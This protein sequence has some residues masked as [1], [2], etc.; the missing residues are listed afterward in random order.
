MH[1]NRLSF[2]TRLFV[3]FGTMLAFTLLALAAYVKSCHDASR[4]MDEILHRYS[5]KLDVGAQI[6]LATTEMQGSQRGLMLSYAMNDPHAAEQYIQLYATSGTKI[7]SV[8]AEI[9][10][11]LGSEAERRLIADIRRNR[12]TWAPRFQKLIALCE[13]GKIDEAYKLRNENKLI[14]AEMHRAATEWVKQQRKALEEAGIA[15][16]ASASTAIWFSVVLA[17][18]SLGL[19]VPI[20]VGV[21]R[22]V[23]RIRRMVEELRKD[24]GQVASASAQ[25]SSSSQ[26]VASGASQQAASIQATSE[27]AGEITAMTRK[28]AEHSASAAQLTAG[29]VELIAEAN[30]SLDRMQAAMKEVTASCQG[31]GRITKVVD[32]IAFQTNILA[33]NAAVEAARAGEAGVGFAV[34]ADEVRNLAQRSASAARE[35]SELI[36]ASIGKSRDGQT[37]LQS[38]SSAIG[39]VTAGAQEIA[40]LVDQIRIGNTEQANEVH[41]VAQAIGDMEQTTQSSAAAA[42]ETAAVGEEMKG[43]AEALR[44]LVQNLQVIV[45]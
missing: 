25:L 10:P 23:R 22:I 12:E 40:S 35:T 27:F 1:L 4:Q 44:T 11:Q 18:I 29:A 5:R 2:G 21:R 43:H 14:S 19:T 16:A 8:L 3:A 7:D 41:S 9:A 32:E 31:V 13:E 28:N 38:V 45:G 6:E 30:G 26:V 17:A 42:E 39:K 34:V 33:L 15:A 36:A 24:A 20:L 37:H